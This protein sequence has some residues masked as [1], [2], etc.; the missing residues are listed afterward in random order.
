MNR[1]DIYMLLDSLENS[2]WNGKRILGDITKNKVNSLLKK[3]DIYR[4]CHQGETCFILGNG[5]SLKSETRL[6]ELANYTVFSVNQFY[7]SE[8]F[9]EVRP[10]YHVM[11]DPLFFS[12]NPDDPADNDTLSRIKKIAGNEDVKMIF[13]VDH[14]DYIK[15]TIGY[16]DNHIYVKARY[17]MH[18]NYKH[19]FNLTKYIP[20][21]L[22]VV[23][24]AI[25][26]AIYMGFTQIVV[27]GC[28]MTGIMD[29]YIRRTPDMNC[30]KFS[31]IYEYT[32][33][34]KNR[35]KKVH[36]SFDN[37]F[38]LNG[39]YTMFKD[40]K[41]IKNICD[42]MEIKIYN[43]SQTTALDSLPYANLNDILDG[44]KDG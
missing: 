7:R 15:N 8:L 17:R 28:D 38:M 25:Y 27:L 21:S 42:D 14:Y 1:N 11:I 18:N 37:E 32:V 31:H 12:L 29:N 23:Q 2:L 34:E 4:N 41:I 35:M 33:E 3:N 43:A 6:K 20:S 44:L 22:N 36:A 13:P 39:F 10:N 16:S 5:P 19:G 24:T 40:Y 30:E 26:C 9:D